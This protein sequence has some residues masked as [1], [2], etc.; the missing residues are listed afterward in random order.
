MEAPGCSRDRCSWRL[1]CQDHLFPDSSPPPSLCSLP[2]LSYAPNPQCLSG[3]SCGDPLQ[4][5]QP[6]PDPGL[7]PHQPRL[8]CP[9]T[10]SARLLSNSL[11]TPHTYQASFHLLAFAQA[12]PWAYS[13][14]SISPLTSFTTPPGPGLVPPLSSPT[15][16]PHSGLSSLLPLLWSLHSHVPVTLWGLTPPCSVLDKHTR[17]GRRAKGQ[18]DG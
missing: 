18:D 2:P 6:Y 17:W 1:V 8:P 12:I 10:H 15:A 4:I 7:P 9:A 11:P 3:L 16:P 13:T 14:L 5:P